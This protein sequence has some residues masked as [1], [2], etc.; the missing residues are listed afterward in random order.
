MS[1]MSFNVLAT[2]FVPKKNNEIDLKN[3]K[4]EIDLKN[5]MNDWRDSNSD[6][7]DDTHFSKYDIENVEKPAVKRNMQKVIEELKENAPMVPKK[8]TYLEALM[9]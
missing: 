6:L 1:E 3:E 9:Q 7:L 4:N 8:R 2:E 5:A